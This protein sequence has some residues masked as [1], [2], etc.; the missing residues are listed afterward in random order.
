MS[1]TKGTLI[2]LYRLCP[3]T[4]GYTLLC[5]RGLFHCSIS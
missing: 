4:F 3:E 1:N 2:F 5:D